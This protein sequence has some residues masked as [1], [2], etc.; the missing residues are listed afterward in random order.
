MSLVS[1]VTH[2]DRQAWENYTIHDGDA[3][4]YE[5]G[6][7]YQKDIG[8]DDLDN[9]PQLKTDDPN[10]ELG[11]GIANYIYDFERIELGKGV[12]S[13][14]SDIYLPTWQVSNFQAP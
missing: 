13:P 11:T 10:L 12:I 7:E 1:K 6:R 5:N 4:W 9:R 2:E 8:I 3:S 14:Q